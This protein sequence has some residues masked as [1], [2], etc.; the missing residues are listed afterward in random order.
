MLSRSC[1]HPDYCHKSYQWPLHQRNGGKVS[2]IAPMQ[3]SCKSF[4]SRNMLTH[5][6]SAVYWWNKIGVTS[7]QTF[8]SWKKAGLSV[9]SLELAWNIPIRSLQKACQ[10][11]LFQ[12]KMPT[13]G[14][15][16]IAPAS[17]FF[18]YFNYVNYTSAIWNPRWRRM[19]EHRQSH[20]NIV[21]REQMLPCMSAFTSCQY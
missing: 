1:F 7:I 8:I 15:F 21:N 19:A 2:S 10:F 18:V 17:T 13:P 5:L 3:A 4:C 12:S 9:I 16:N 20:N 11:S 14:V 6:K